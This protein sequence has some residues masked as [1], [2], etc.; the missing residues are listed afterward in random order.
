MVQPD[1]II[2]G[3]GPTGLSIAVALRKYNIN[4][5]CIGP[6]IAHHSESQVLD[7]RTTALFQGSVRYL[8]NIGVWEKC[9]AYAEPLQAIRIIDV[10][11]R[12]LRAPEL[13]FQASELGEE[14]FGY[15]I[16]NTLLIK[17]LHDTLN[18]DVASHY[19]A[20][21]VHDICIQND[22]IKIVLSDGQE[23]RTHL[24]IGADGRNSLC[25]KAAKIDLFSWQYPQT[26]VACNF[27]HSKTH[28]NISN[29]FHTESGPFT[30]VPLGKNAS[31]LVWVE[32]PAKADQLMSLDNI[33]FQLELEKNLN[34]LLGQ[35]HEIGPRGCF[36][37]SGLTAKTF[38]QNRIALIGE[39]A[40]VMPPI[41]AQG[42]NLG[43]RDCTM[44][45]ECL[46]EA[47][48]NN[49]DFG[50]DRVLSAYNKK[51]RTD[52]WSRTFSVDLL[53]RSLLSGFLPLQAGRFLGMSVLRSIGPLRRFVMRQGMQPDFAVPKL[54]T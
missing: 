30:T 23:F 37:L 47:Y 34:G 48:Q 19:I 54:F 1:I 5:L 9:Q 27:S 35:V 44:L 32:K 39:A 4:A 6:K 28:Q 31:S 45:V 49:Q 22:T 14:S 15:N 21:E 24:L 20:G 7:T 52:V 3:A 46:H 2:V 25:R 41:G 13:L 40:H 50:E 11:K 51:R 26:A 10:T 18:N 17:Q 36:P 29:E 38:A 16:A 33:N 53:N 12:F 43:F 8:K 42:L